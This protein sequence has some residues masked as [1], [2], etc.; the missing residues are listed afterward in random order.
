M[1]ATVVK[2]NR[3]V[4]LLEAWESLLLFY[5]AY[6]ISIFYVKC[7]GKVTVPCPVSAL[8]QGIAPITRRD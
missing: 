1:S 3:R 5:G 4:V 6:F 2:P 8:L 7:V